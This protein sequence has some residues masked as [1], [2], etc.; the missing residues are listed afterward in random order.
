MS[1]ATT[2]SSNWGRGSGA[3]GAA[4]PMANSICLLGSVSSYPFQARRS[5]VGLGGVLVG[6]SRSMVWTATGLQ[7]YV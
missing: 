2:R 3:R 4:M 1:A 5:A 6:S 7:G